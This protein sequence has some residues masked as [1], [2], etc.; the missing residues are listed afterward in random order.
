[1]MKLYGSLTSP[2]TRK[3]RVLIV[4]KR[5]DCE[6]VVCDPWL[7]DSPVPLMNPLGK[8]PVLELEPDSFVFES[9]LVVSYL[10]NLD[11]KPLLPKDAAGY[12]RSQWWQALAQGLIDATV[13][14]LHETR[15]PVDKQLP[16]TIERE[17]T[18]IMRAL[19]T[20]ER[21]H[22]GAARLAGNAFG[23]ADIALGVAL[24]YIDFR[25]PQDWR[26]RHARLAK[27]LDGV[28]SRKSFEQT[29][30]PGYS[31]S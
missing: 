25:Y 15:R 11:G 4:E 28:A 19:G 3:A 26:S 24:Q 13:A 18:R 17:E 6:F 5:I 29:L 10:D 30:P 14:R 22:G 31:K 20:A 16:Q 12:W 7:V 27:W 21:V 2:Y 23:T 1:M 8:V 9:T